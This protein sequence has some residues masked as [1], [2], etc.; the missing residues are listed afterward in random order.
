MI[1]TDLFKQLAEGVGAGESENIRRIF[2]NL[3]DEKQAK[4]LLAAAPPA[5]VD[6]IAEKTGISAQDVEGM[7]PDLFG[8]GL[9][10]K[11][12]KKQGP[13]KY[14]RVR[15][16]PQLHDS[17]AVYPDVPR[18]VLDL[19]KD[20]MESEWSD[21][22]LQMDSVMPGA[23]VRVLP[24]NESVEPE[25]RILAPDDVRDA[26]EKARSL[27]VTKCSCRVI[28]GKCGKP[29]DVCIQLDRAA[30]YSV[31][32]GTGRRI[33]AAEAVEI[34]EMCEQEGLVHVA[35]NR[36]PVGHVI[37]NCCDDCC[38]NWSAIRA[39]AKKWVVPS[40][41]AAVVDSELCEAC[42]TCMETCFFDAIVIVDDAVRVDPDAC[43]GCGVCAVSCP[44]AAISLKEIRPADFIP[45]QAK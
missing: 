35:D 12:S 28:D 15:H 25:S 31:E 30:D 1:Q 33:D 29:L 11:S 17:T 6:E 14:Y 19:W 40:R 7:I 9:I 27:A 26:V 24:I 34:L 21:Y 3:V 5:T 42:E 16:V 22:S 4:V 43:M 38:M 36:Y 23:V 44:S 45:Q 20:F 13:Q 10:F 39:G 32:R 37:C 18:K 2:E 41:F 8:K